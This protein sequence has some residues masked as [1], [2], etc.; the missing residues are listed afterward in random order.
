MT[1]WYSNQIGNET[2]NP[3]N[4]CTDESL[5]KIPMPNLE[6]MEQQIVT[7][8]KYHKKKR[9]MKGSKGNKS[10]IKK[11]YNYNINKKTQE[12]KTKKIHK[13]VYVK[14]DKYKTMTKSDKVR[15]L[16]K[17][18]SIVYMAIGVKR[19]NQAIMVYH[20]SVDLFLR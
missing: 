14:Q 15:Q 8:Y 6:I 20:W 12:N 13:N 16:S 9:K 1:L 11:E 17:I 4:N 5:S 18:V 19:I 2:T 10:N 7:I 3:Y